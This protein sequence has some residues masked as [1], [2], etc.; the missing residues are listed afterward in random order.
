MVGNKLKR[1]PV[2]VGIQVFGTAFGPPK[3]VVPS[4][5]MARRVLKK[6]SILVIKK[7]AEGPGFNPHRSLFFIP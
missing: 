5:S 4:V 2:G 7:L 6:G 3:C 1:L